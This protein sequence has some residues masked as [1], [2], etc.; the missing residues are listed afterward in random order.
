LISKWRKVTKNFEQEP[1]N[2]RGILF[3]DIYLIVAN[4]WIL[5]RIY[6]IYI[7]HGTYS[8]ADLS[9]GT[10]IAPRHERL[11]SRVNPQLVDAILEA[12]S[13]TFRYV[14]RLMNDKVG[15]IQ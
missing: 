4:F 9:P 15:S 6:N 14:I 1:R 11:V 2:S 10:G 3:S 13:L 12:I 5:S 8:N 7:M